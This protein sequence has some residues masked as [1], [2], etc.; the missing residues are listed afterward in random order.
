MSTVCN[1]IKEVK[2]ITDTGPD[3]VELSEYVMDHF[4][5]HREQIR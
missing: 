3:L 5:E 1:L 4:L 2:R